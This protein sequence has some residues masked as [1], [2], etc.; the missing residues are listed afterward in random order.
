[1]DLRRTTRDRQTLFYDC[2]NS[3]Y[4]RTGTGYLF[5]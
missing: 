5:N 4:K 3:E 2:L 1:M